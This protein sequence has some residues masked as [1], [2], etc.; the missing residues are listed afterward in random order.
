MYLVLSAL[1]MRLYHRL[2]VQFGFPDG[3]GAVADLGGLSADSR[4]SS[5]RDDSASSGAPRLDESAHGT[6]P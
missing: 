2:P 3:N 1:D 5:E 4:H 6:R